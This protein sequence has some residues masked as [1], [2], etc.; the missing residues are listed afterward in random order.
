LT[1]NTRLRIS[2]SVMKIKQE[3][4]KYFST[5]KRI[6]LTM[7][8]KII[9]GLKILAAHRDTSVSMILDE[10]AEELLAKEKTEM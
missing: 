5:K 3:K 4:K 6:T 1:F 8:A 10:L 2:V 7:S 9:K